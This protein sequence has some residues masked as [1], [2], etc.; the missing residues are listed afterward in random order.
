MGSLS[1]L[2][3]SG[4]HDCTTRRFAVSMVQGIQ[5][6]FLRHEHS[7]GE[8]IVKF[9]QQGCAFALIATGLWFDGP[10]C[11]ETFVNNDTILIPGGPGSIYPSIINVSGVLGVVSDLNV[12]VSSITH[13]FS[14]DLDILLVGPN[15]LNVMLMAGA[16]GS[17]VLVN[18]QFTFDDQAGQL[19]PNTLPPLISGTYQPSNYEPLQGMPL[20]APQGPYGS[21]LSAFNGMNPNGQWK[22]YVADDGAGDTG[23]MQGWSLQ[24]NVVPA[25]GALALFALACIKCSRRRR[26]I[27]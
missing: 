15:G 27:T 12:T 18:A 24:F 1:T 25:P 5:Q 19:M 13:T 8:V 20:P 22:L 21:L 26:S 3:A 23:S 6:R 11:G 9:F 17:T 16:G 7:G 14:D 10:A 4:I 2:I